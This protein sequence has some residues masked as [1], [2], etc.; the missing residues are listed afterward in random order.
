MMTAEMSVLSLSL[1]DSIHRHIQ[2]MAEKEGVSVDQ[3]IAGAVVEKVSAIAAEDYLR[4]RAM[5]ADPAA[6]R[7]ILAKTP[8]R[9]PMPGDE[10]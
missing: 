7:A 6:F 10:L 2:E 8:N 4:A 1:P 9:E 5:R 3:F